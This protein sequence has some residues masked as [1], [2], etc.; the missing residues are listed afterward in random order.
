MNDRVKSEDTICKL[1]EN[2]GLIEDGQHIVLGLSGGPDSVC[3]FD[4]LKQLSDKKRIHIYPVHVNHMIRGKDAD[5]DQAYVKA[6][7]KENGITCRIVRFNCKKTAEELGVTTEETGRMKRYEAF[8]ET[9]KNIEAEGTDKS[10]IVIAT[11]HNADDQVETILFRILRGT[12]I[13]GLSG[14]K[15]LRRD[16]SGFS[17]IKPLLGVRKADINR[18]CEEKSLNPCKDN[19]NEQAIYDRNRIRL[20]LI[21]YLKKYNPNIEEGILRLGNSAREDSELL[22]ECS[23]ISYDAHFAGENPFEIIFDEDLKTVAAPFRRRAVAR[24]FAKLGLEDDVSFSHYELMDKVMESDSPSAS[25]DLPKGYKFSRR[26]DKLALTAPCEN[27]RKIP[28]L[29]TEKM[30]AEF[31][32]EAEYEKGRFAAFDAEL[33]EKEYGADFDSLI[34]VRSRKAGDFLSGKTGRKKIQDLFVDEKIP[35][36]VRDEIFL[37]AIGNEILFIPMEKGVFN[38]ARYNGKYFLSEDTKNAFI[39]EIFS[40]V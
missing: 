2:S 4:V 17:V 19:T 40:A 7:C 11:A 3:L 29:R 36:M 34:E 8:A 26:Y 28:L 38:K 30:A 39:I 33:L 32:D 31:Y 12:G 6:L 15:E 16:K 22:E 23:K 35:K 37:A 1:V 27:S 14:M 5:R 10:K 25:A 13:D 21:P 24:G 9:A 18:Y 20:E